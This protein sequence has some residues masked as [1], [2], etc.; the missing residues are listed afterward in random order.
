MRPLRA[1][2]VSYRLGQLDGVSVEAAKWAGA[3]RRLGLSVVTVAGAGAADRLVPGLGAWDRRPPDQQV[4]AEALSDADVVVAE[5]ICSLPLNPAASAATAA[6]LRGRPAVLR[7]HDLP[8]QRPGM[9]ARVPDDPA[10]VHVTVNE[11]SRRQLAERGIEAVTVYNCFC[12]RPPQGDREATRAAL[13]VT[14]QGLLFLQPT[15]A[16]P[17]KDVPAGLALA[18]AFGATFWLTGP[19]EEGYGPELARRFRR[20]RVPVIHRPA[21]I[22]MAGAYAAADVVVLPSTWEGFG[23]PAVEASL[24]GRPVVIGPY[25]VAGELLSLGFGW[26]SLDERPALGAW[27][28]SPD[29]GPLE[30]NREVA[31]RRLSLADLPDRIRPLLESALGRPLDPIPAG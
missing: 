10:W 2:I 23:N 3:L 7:H 18:E 1:T 30:H 4:L 12:P 8:W 28:S 24:H 9:T 21:P 19:A 25:P 6:A 27:L 29:P 11:L 14:D 17:R 16:I 15:R 20:A 31:R 26:F 22:D 13:S 5:N